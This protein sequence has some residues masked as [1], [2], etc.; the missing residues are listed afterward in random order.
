MTITVAVI[1]GR[2]GRV[3][4]STQAR[5]LLT[6]TLTEVHGTGAIAHLVMRDPNAM[7]VVCLT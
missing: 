6:C 1:A 5:P 3:L 4:A 2:S 7:Q